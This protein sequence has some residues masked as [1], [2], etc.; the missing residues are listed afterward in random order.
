MGVLAFLAN[1]WLGRAAVALFG[2][3]GIFVSAYLRGR[4]AA[5]AS[6]AEQT[7]KNMKKR[8]ETDEKISNLSPDARRRELSKW[9][10]DD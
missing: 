4:A 2:A 5:K 6:Q 10:R 7:L 3:A 8:E 9:V 1:T